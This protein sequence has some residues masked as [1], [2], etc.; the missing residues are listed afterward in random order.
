MDWKTVN[1]EQLTPMMRHYVSIK[2]EHPDCIILYRLGDFYE[3]FFSDAVTASRVLELALTA[4]DCGLE[5]RAPMCGVP[6][7]VVDGFVSKLVAAG[8]KVA[9]VDQMEDPAQAQGLV[10]R[11]VT[12]II[13]PGTLTDSD[14]LVQTENNYLLAF[15]FHGTRMGLAYADISTGEIQATELEGINN[16]ESVLC[17]WVTALKPSEL[18]YINDDRILQESFLE[19]PSSPIEVDLGFLDQQNIFVTELSPVAYDLRGVDRE[20]NKHLSRQS[21]KDLIDRLLAGIALAGLLDYVYRFQDRP[22]DHLN[23]VE[24]IHPEKIL[25]MNASTRENL[26]IQRNL[27]DRTKRNSLLSVLD[28]CKTAMGSRLVNRWSEMPLLDRDRIEER[29]DMVEGLYQNLLVRKK[30]EEEMSRI[31]D[32]ERLLSKF[33]YNRGNARDMLSLQ[34]S[35]APLPGLK[36][37][38][39]SMKHP[40]FNQMAESLDCLEDIRIPIEEAIREEAPILLTEGGLIKQG[41]SPELDEIREGSDRARK[42]LKEYEQEEKAR[43]GIKNLRIIELKN[44]EIFIEIT[45]SFLDRVPE[46]YRRR[47]TL[48]NAERFVTDELENLKGRINNNEQE[49]FNLEY[50]IFQGLREKIA[51]R[52]MGIQETANL[53]AKLDVLVSFAKVAERNNYCR[54]IFTDADEIRIVN[55]RH[56]VIEQQTGRFIPN[57][58]RIGS[59][60]NRIQIITGPNMAGKSTFM[61]QNALIIVMAQMGSFVPCDECYLPITD[62]I[63]TR[64]GAMDNLASGDSTFMVEM[65]EMASILRDATDRS[66]LVLDEVGR[67]TSTN[68]GLS[69]AYAIV[70]HLAEKKPAK[71]LFATHY[72]ELTVLADRYNPVQNRKVDIEEEAGRLIFLRKVVEGRAD[73]SYGIEVA[74]LS[75]LPQ[76]ILDRASYLLANIDDL[77]DVSFL[78]E[79]N[80]E[81]LNHSTFN[82]FR[83]EALLDELVGTDINAL[84]P[85]EAM[86]ALHKFIRQAEDIRKK[87]GL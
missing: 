68:D 20:L 82:D 48:K 45:N 47:R 38:L 83:K 19:A 2:R 84:S 58:L 53:I 33:A 26:E 39:R 40:L 44:S 17:D 70:E 77:N 13:T 55:G 64:I 78:S 12:R 43:T 65:K 57:N 4:R 49:I 67:G 85:I 35:L 56:P 71:T 69:I 72:H 54:P 6:H 51:S 66:F 36:D 18:L 59:P 7:H 27:N 46:D 81:S 21:R 50:E 63:F 41:Y 11:A 42:R 31:Y 25:R 80:D 14:S 9:L 34:I 3:M 37:L 75:G 22:L 73:K 32:L 61:R 16:R 15:Y 76:D 60:N 10:K 23:K 1:F 52:A 86:N 30:I 29:L 24:W 79:M 28:L 5:E 87:E 62:Q 8:H 74:R